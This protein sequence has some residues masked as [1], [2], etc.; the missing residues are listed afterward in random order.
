MY[1]PEIDLPLL[2]AMLVLK[3]HRNLRKASEEL[4]IS[5]AAMNRGL[6]KLRRELNDPLFVSTGHG[7]EPTPRTL[8]I[9]EPISK[10][11]ELALDEISPVAPFDPLTSEREFSVAASDIGE[12]MLIPELMQKCEGFP[13]IQFRSHR[14]AIN[15]LPDELRSGAVDVAVGAFPALESGI[16]CR[17]LF[18]ERYVCLARR[19]HPA[20]SGDFTMERFFEHSHVVV[21]TGMLG[22]AHSL[23]E[24]ALV[25]ML[26]RGSIKA[27]SPS[28]LLSAILVGESDC[29]LVAP[30][31][32][33]RLM[34]PRLNL[35]VLTCPFDAMPFDIFMYWHERVHNEPAHRWFR[36]LII[37]N[38]FQ[39]DA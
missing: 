9:I 11:I 33:A 8:A 37:Q 12:L 14:L 10:I 25:K 2:R 23:V 3:K 16:H 5:Q 6:A 19:G 4:G 7:M 30:S 38:F 21:S 20:L 22:H 18:T 34:K 24:N 15:S 29:L 1:L 36:S 39:A 17:R 32:L 13:N 35:E 28:F 31:T 26:P 27:V